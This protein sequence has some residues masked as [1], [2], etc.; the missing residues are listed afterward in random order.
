[1]YTPHTENVPVAGI[2]ELL[3]H[4]SRGTPYTPVAAVD[5]LHSL[6]KALSQ[7]CSEINAVLGSA[8]LRQARVCAVADDER[9]EGRAAG[10][11]HVLGKLR[12]EGGHIQ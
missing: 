2:D 6:R 12:G 1:M 7:Q 5:L 10:G 4:K 3:Q 11:G 8:E 9:V